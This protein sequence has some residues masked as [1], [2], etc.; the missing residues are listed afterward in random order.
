MSS[1]SAAQ[2]HVHGPSRRDV[3]TRGATNLCAFSPVT[4]ETC[5]PVLLWNWTAHVN[6]SFGL[7]IYPQNV[8]GRTRRV[9]TDSVGKEK[10]PPHR[11]RS[12]AWGEHT[13]L[14]SVSAPCT[15]CPTATQDGTTDAPISEEETEARKL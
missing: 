5:G 8:L 3:P 15:G 12:Q 4:V 10:S 7:F 11:G 13:R 14:C 2:L 6:N 1:C 9:C